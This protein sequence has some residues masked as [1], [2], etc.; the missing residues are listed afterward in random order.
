MARILLDNSLTDHL[1]FITKGTWESDGEVGSIFVGGSAIVVGVTHVQFSLNFS[2]TSIGMYGHVLPDD[3]PS[4]DTINQV[5]LDSETS[6]NIFIPANNTVVGLWYQSPSLPDTNEH[7]VTFYDFPTLLI[8][9]ALVTPGKDT[10]L[11]GQTLLVDDADASIVYNGNWTRSYAVINGVNS[12]SRNPVGG[13]TLQTEDEAASATFQFAGT[14]LSVF[15]VSPSQDSVVMDFTL[16]GNLT[17]SNIYNGTVVDPNFLWFSQ[18][19]LFAGNHTLSM[20]F[21]SN[22][23]TRNFTIDYITYAPSFSTLATQPTFSLEPTATTNSSSHSS[24]GLPTYLIPAIVG[25]IAFAIF[26]IAFIWWWRRRMTSRRNKISALEDGSPP[27]GILQVQRKPRLPARV[28]P[29]IEHRRDQ[30]VRQRSED[31]SSSS[32][33]LSMSS[34][35]AWPPGEIH[36]PRLLG[37]GQR[38]S[39]ALADIDPLRAQHS[40]L[41]TSISAEG[42]PPREIHK[43]RLPGDELQC[44]EETSSL[45]QPENLSSISLA[46]AWPPSEIHKPRLPGDEPQR[47]FAS[48]DVSPLQEQHKPLLTS[49]SSGSVAHHVVDVPLFLEAGQALPEDASES[50]LPLDVIHKPPLPGRTGL[51]PED[52][53]DSA[54]P[55]ASLSS[56]S[57][58]PR[59]PHFL[60][61][62]KPRISGSTSRPLPVVRNGSAQV[63]AQR[64]P[65]MLNV[66]IQNASAE[67]IITVPPRAQRKRVTS[68]R[69]SRRT[70]EVVNGG[71]TNEELNTPSSRPGPDPPNNTDDLILDSPSTLG[72]VSPTTRNSNGRWWQFR[73]NEQALVEPFRLRSPISSESDGLDSPL[74]STRSRVGLDR[75]NDA[76]TPIEQVHGA[77]GRVRMLLESANRRLTVLENDRRM[78]VDVPPP[79]YQNNS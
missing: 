54:P 2:G 40:P 52:R 32:Q 77:G 8:D 10:L 66:A 57:E 17:K 51:S 31:T 46:A 56:L 59:S 12:T 36:K 79:P 70:A 74:S 37:D 11:T 60:E 30:E 63:A 1:T 76:P 24:G 65:R 42:W 55:N 35:A 27:A 23:P 78:G 20:K 15:G 47:P 62:R 7:N 21:A 53:H 19:N 44:S 29:F 49:N 28:E 41:E 48:P 9:Y 67:D 72:S 26:S 58:P 3:F 71:P 69:S 45:S 33:N 6:T 22:S 34:A 25:P 50:S 39:F 38:R 64:K 73:R 14:S 75:S 61:Q 4:N 16:D 5:I 18:N 68:T 13:S 43:P